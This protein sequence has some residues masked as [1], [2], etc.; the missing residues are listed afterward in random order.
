LFQ[1][2]VPEME[3]EQMA[4][5]EREIRRWCWAPGWVL[6]S[7]DEDLL[8]MDAAQAPWLLDEARRGCPKRTYVLQIVAHGVRDRLHH[9]LWE[10]AGIAAELE[11]A[12]QLLPLA[13][14]TRDPELVAYLERIV[15]YAESRSVSSAEVVQRVRDLR[16]CHPGSEHAPRIERRG[17]HWCVPLARANVRPGTLHID[18]DSG[19]MF[20]R[21]D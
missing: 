7:Q 19:R 5:E 18:V 3:H 4:S 20:A 8:L 16:R 14:G 13:R 2:G 21:E 17:S 9:A 1:E 10:D 6:L 15:S 11:A 12:A